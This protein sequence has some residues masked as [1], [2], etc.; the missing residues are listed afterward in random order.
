MGSTL[1]AAA[2]SG[3]VIGSVLVSAIS[4]RA[5]FLVN[6]PIALVAVLVLRRATRDGTAP[7]GSVNGLDSS[8][9]ALLGLAML[10]AV[11]AISGTAA[12]A[13]GP[14]AAGLLVA[15]VLRERRAREPI[16]QLSLFRI[17]A[18]AVGNAISVLTSVGF[19][20][21]FFLQSLYLQGPLGY[22]ALLGGVLL[23]PLGAATLLSST[24]GGRLSDRWGSRLPMVAGLVLTTAAPLLLSRVD[25]QSNYVTEVL[26][27]YVL[28]GLGWGLV[29]APL[30]ALV[31]GAATN[32]HSGEAAGVMGTLD[33][34]GGAVGVAIAGGL[35]AGAGFLDAFAETM[36]V[37]AAA[38]GLALALSVVGLTRTAATAAR[39]SRRAR[40]RTSP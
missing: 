3:P 13:L 37:A 27:A 1:A 32:A 40:A 25:A 21:M 34:L 12:V 35:L 23:V 24:I 9:A 38:M 8:G 6:L 5:I 17:R 30:N 18:Y 28:E 7:T 19:F 16:V 2:A 36:L 29:S 31:I 10:G 26:P 14:A 15:F 11:L 4:W 39:R 22:S 33:K 20:G